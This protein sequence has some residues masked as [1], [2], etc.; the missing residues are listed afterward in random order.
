MPLWEAVE[1]EAP[2]VEAVGGLAMTL[3]QVGVV[4]EATR[5]TLSPQTTWGAEEAAGTW[6]SAIITSMAHP[7]RLAGFPRVLQ[8]MLLPPPS[9]RKPIFTSMRVILLRIL[10]LE[11]SGSTL[12]TAATT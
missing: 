11:Q 1:D 5:A 12:A 10:A 4:V 3:P 8:P 9:T 2:F 6:P 7:I